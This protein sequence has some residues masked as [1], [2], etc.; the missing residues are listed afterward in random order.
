MDFLKIDFLKT[1]NLYK[2]YSAIYFYKESFYAHCT[3]IK[4]K[5]FDVVIYYIISIKLKLKN[6]ISYS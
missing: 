1:K 2:K 4:Y 3:I 5:I 6:I